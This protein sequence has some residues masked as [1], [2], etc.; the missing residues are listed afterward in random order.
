ML[1]GMRELRGLKKNRDYSHKLY[2]KDG[3]GHRHMKSQSEE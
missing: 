1:Y 2:I 3:N